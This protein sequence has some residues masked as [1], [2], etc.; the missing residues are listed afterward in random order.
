MRLL[1]GLILQQEGAAQAV[2][3]MALQ[4]GEQPEAGLPGVAAGGV[5]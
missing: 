1:L 3:R 2:S 5:I 4:G